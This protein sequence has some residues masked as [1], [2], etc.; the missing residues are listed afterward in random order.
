MSQ[1]VSVFDILG[2]RIT[3]EKIATA[4]PNDKPR[5]LKIDTSDHRALCSRCGVDCNSKPH[6]H[7]EWQARPRCPYCKRDD[8][9]HRFTP[10]EGDALC[11]LTPA[12]VRQ[13]VN[14]LLRD[15]GL[16]RA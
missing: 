12:K 4:V 3:I 11:P 10:T 16:I 15:R 14:A 5:V 7:G 2:Y 8:H 9:D 1:T 13:T 6:K